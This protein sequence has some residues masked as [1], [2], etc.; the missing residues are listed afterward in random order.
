MCRDVTV[1]LRVWEDIEMLLDTN[2][3]EKAI[4]E[5]SYQL[6]NRPERGLKI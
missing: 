1:M 5:L 4:Y 3:L 6:S 2:S